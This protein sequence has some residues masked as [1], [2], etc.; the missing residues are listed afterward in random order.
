MALNYMTL[1]M[2]YPNTLIPAATPCV[3]Q[4]TLCKAIM[5]A[6]WRD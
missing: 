5:R 3:L 6:A 1:Y 2:K 4:Q